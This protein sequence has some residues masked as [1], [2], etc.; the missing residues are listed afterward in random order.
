MVNLAGM[1]VF[2]GLCD[3][4]KARL[5]EWIAGIEDGHA[6]EIRNAAE[7][8]SRQYRFHPADLMEIQRR[9]A[10]ALAVQRGRRSE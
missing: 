5:L 9:E 8:D 1:P 6:P 10:A 4:L 7:R 3:E 2:R